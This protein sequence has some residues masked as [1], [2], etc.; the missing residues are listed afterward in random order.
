MPNF[1]SALTTGK[2]HNN[3][4]KYFQLH[5]KKYFALI[6]LRHYEWMVRKNNCRIQK[7]N[8]ENQILSV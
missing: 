3:N 8:L 4:R 7:K 6:G 2:S 1:A 5:L